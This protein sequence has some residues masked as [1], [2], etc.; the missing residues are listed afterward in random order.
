[1]SYTDYDKN[2]KQQ[3]SGFSFD[4]MFKRALTSTTS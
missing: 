2:T 3:G 4:K 1:M